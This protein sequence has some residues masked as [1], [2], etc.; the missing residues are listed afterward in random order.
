M[1]LPAALLD[2]A[3]HSL[4][5]GPV[6]FWDWDDTVLAS[7]FLSGKGYRLDS[8]DNFEPEV[9]AGLKELE[10]SVAAMLTMAMRFGHVH[11]VTNAETG[12]VQL[13]CQVRL[14]YQLSESR[15]LSRA[16]IHSGSA[17][18]VEQSQGRVSTV[19]IRGPLS[20]G[21]RQVE[22]DTCGILNV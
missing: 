21:S 17:A 6:L 18:A 11:I 16:E 2:A 19:D 13:S 1:H 4:V 20:R 22:G 8:A 9:E 7:S 15:A 12:W 10:Q 5:L 14:S 3:A